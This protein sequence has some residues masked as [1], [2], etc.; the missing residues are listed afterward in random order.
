MSPR[1]VIGFHREKVT[2]V[3]I[4]VGSVPLQISYGA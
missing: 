2:L 1:N 4:S 3:D